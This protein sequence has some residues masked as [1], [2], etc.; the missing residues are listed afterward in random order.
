M[1]LTWK[2]GGWMSSEIDTLLKISKNLMQFWIYKEPNLAI[3]RKFF[4]FVH[5]N[6]SSNWLWVTIPIQ[7]SIL[8]FTTWYQQTGLYNFLGLLNQLLRQSIFNTPCREKPVQIGLL[9]KILVA[10]PGSRI[11]DPNCVIPHV[12]GVGKIRCQK[13]GPP[14]Y[15]LY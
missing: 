5:F 13:S 2:G 4:I 10:S 12:M 14:Q 11:N 9:G 15:L 7:G 1:A 6:F 8:Y 3:R